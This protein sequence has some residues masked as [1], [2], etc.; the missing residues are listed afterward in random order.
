MIKIIWIN[1]ALLWLLLFFGTWEVHRTVQTSESFV[2]P[3]GDHAGRITRLEKNVALN[4]TLIGMDEVSV[5]KLRKIQWENVKE[6]RIY[7]NLEKL[8]NAKAVKKSG[9]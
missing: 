3:F 9:Q 4:R 2:L 5:E 1:I 6:L 7:H 8:K